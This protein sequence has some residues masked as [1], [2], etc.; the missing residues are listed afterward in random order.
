MCAIEMPSRLKRWLRTFHTI[1]HLQPR[2]AWYFFLRRVV[3]PNNIKSSQRDLTRQPILA[4]QISVHPVLALKHNHTEFQNYSF[5]F[6]NYT[7]H[8]PLD[9][10]NWS[11]SQ[12]Q[13]LWRYNLHYFD[14]LRDPE[15]SQS[16]KIAL[17]DHWIE[18]NPQG[19]EPAWEP[20]TA[21]LRIVNW[22]VFF[23]VIAQG[24]N[25]R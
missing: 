2:Q 18:Y 22:C 4:R 20:Y 21:S 23:L 14:F 12:T 24:K 11:P 1:K 6:L 16:Q 13:R 10:M 25:F 7:L 5:T 3:G 9:A 19:S 17:I 8:F 15:R